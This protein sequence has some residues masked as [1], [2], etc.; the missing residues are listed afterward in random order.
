MKTNEVND[1][2]IGKRCKS[3]FTGLMVAGTIEAINITEY[4]AEVKVRFDELHNWGNDIYEY[5]WSY[6]R[7]ADEFGSLHHLQ[8]IDDK[9]KAIKVTFSQSIKEISRMF[10][11][12][13]TNWQTVNLKEWIDNY[14]S[15]RFTPIDERRA[16]ITSE[17]NMEHI[18]EWLSKNTPVKAIET[19]I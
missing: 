19:L 11:S 10:T 17:Y 6:A 3:V 5:D 4:S 8:I 15:S 2:I 13:Y 16:I 1:S 12:D 18:K 14:E 9:Y 7:L